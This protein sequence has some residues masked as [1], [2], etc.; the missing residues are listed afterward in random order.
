MVLGIHL[1]DGIDDDAVAADTQ[2]MIAQ[3]KETL[4]VVAQ[5]ASLSGASW[6]TIFRIE[7]KHQLLAS[8]ISESYSIPIFVFSLKIGS[9]GTFL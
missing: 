6:S 8:E 5:V 2:H 9:F 3:R 1:A 4:I 7:I